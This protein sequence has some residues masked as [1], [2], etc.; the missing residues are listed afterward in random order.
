MLKFNPYLR[1]K[2]VDNEVEFCA[3]A[4]KD[5]TLCESCVYFEN[6]PHHPPMCCGN[7]YKEREDANN[8]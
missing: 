1:E 4:E 5:E 7:E 3:D 6:T 8:D 2:I